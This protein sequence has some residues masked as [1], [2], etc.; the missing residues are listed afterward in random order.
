MLE[1]NKGVSFVMP[2]VTTEFLLCLA[3]SVDGARVNDANRIPTDNRIKGFLTQVRI[4]IFKRIT[5]T[6]YYP[7]IECA[8][9][10]GLFFKYLRITTCWRYKQY[11][12][13][14]D[15]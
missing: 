14:Y 6:K 5:R 10:K 8:R 4:R 3:V 1:Y 15:K 9:N 13:M 2:G 11:G 12:K 7:I